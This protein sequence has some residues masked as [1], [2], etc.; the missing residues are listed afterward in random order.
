VFEQPI[1][2]AVELVDLRQF[3]VL[4]QE[5]GHGAAIEPFNRFCRTFS[6]LSDRKGKA[7][8]R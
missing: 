4:A 5:V 1:V 2:R 7:L 8:G 6:T 3:D